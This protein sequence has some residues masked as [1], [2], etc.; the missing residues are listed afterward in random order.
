MQVEEKWVGHNTHTR[1]FDD[2]YIFFVSDVPV[3]QVSEVM[4]FNVDTMIGLKWDPQN[5]VVYPDNAILVGWN[6]WDLLIRQRHHTN[7]YI[8]I[9]INME[10]KKNLNHNP[11][12]GRNLKAHWCFIPAAAGA[13]GI[14]PRT[15]Y[16]GK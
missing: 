13:T 5:F 9:S 15:V 8:I 2:Y 11:R 16:T 4:H 7:T 1:T 12:R 3:A 6:S 10:N 14:E